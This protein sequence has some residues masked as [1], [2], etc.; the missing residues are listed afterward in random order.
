MRIALVGC[1]RMGERHIRALE[2]WSLVGVCDGSVDALLRMQNNFDIDEKMLFKNYQEMIHQT[3]PDCVIVA[4]TATSHCELVCHAAERGVRYIL[5]EKPMATSIQDCLK[6]IEVCEV[7]N[8]LL[9]VNHQMR[10]MDQ[11][12]VPKKRIESEDFGGLTSISMMAGNYGVSMN[13]T[14]YFEMFRFLSGAPVESVQSWLT[15]DVIGNP[16]GEQFRDSGGCIRAISS[17]GKRFYMDISP[18]QGH[19]CS[20]IYSG[21]FGQI[22]VDE[23]SMIL[24]SSFRKPEYRDYPTTR[25]ALPHNRDTYDL[26]PLDLVQVT[27]NLLEDLFRGSGY[28]CGQDGLHAIQVAV[29]CYVSSEQRGD[30]IRLSELDK[31]ED[32]RFPWA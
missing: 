12:N 10:Y 22:V 21:K 16:R 24:T 18:E 30:P 11:F 27:S 29:A 32:R 26:P 14:H 7:N 20:V 1:G 3:T 23:L 19:G 25:T 2:S 6:M 17:N 15:D 31:F 4:T 8:V 13:G 5:C 28:P 9:A